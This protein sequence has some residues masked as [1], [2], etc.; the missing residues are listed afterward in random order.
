MLTLI[1]GL[2]RSGKTTY[3]KQYENVVHLDEVGFDYERCKEFVNNGEVVIEGVYNKISQRKSLLSVYHGEATK[4]I[5]LNTPLEV[6]KTRKGYSTHSNIFFEP[7]TLNE[8]W[9]EIIIIR[10]NDDVECISR[11]EQT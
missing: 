5:W 9:D 4:C 7:P 6:R 2:S 3:S 8:G 10:G 1:C 11:K